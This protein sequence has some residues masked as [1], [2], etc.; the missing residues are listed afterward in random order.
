[1]EVGWQ[2]DSGPVCHHAEATNNTAFDLGHH[3]LTSLAFASLVGPP[4]AHPSS[5][6]GLRRVDGLFHG[7]L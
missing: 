2:V 6:A 4:G 3:H 5:A 1:M 7:S